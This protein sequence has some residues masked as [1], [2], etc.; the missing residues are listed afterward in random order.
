MLILTWIVVETPTLL[1][2]FISFTKS[3]LKLKDKEPVHF[4]VCFLLCLMSGLHLF[5]FKSAN[6]TCCS[7]HSPARA[8][9]MRQVIA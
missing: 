5:A 9:S 7:W 1:S 3:S 6:H 4:C 2:S 8:F